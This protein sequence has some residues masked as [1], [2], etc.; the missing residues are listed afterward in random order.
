[1]T[2]SSVVSQPVNKVR[3]VSGFTRSLAAV[4]KA[5]TAPVTPEPKGDSNSWLARHAHVALPQKEAA[6]RL[7]GY[8]EHAL[9]MHSNTRNPY[10][11][12]WCFP[13]L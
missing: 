3:V 8:S 1:M 5:K 6:L 13:W 11:S 10:H 12:I 2:T 9:H 7:Q 4:D